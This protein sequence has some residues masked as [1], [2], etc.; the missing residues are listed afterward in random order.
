MKTNPLVMLLAPKAT[1]GVGTAS[2]KIAAALDTNGFEVLPCADILELYQLA[3]EK[4]KPDGPALVLLAGSHAENCV[5]ATYLRTLHPYVGIIVILQGTAEE[6]LLQ[7][8]QAGADTYCFRG[9]SAALLSALILRLQW[10][11]NQRWSQ[12]V[13]HDEPKAGV[14]SLQEQAWSLVTPTGTRVP[15][16]T[17][18]RAFLS[19]LLSAPNQRAT[20]G[21]LIEAVNASYALK[22]PSAQPGRLGVLVSRMRRKLTVHGAVLPLKSMHNWGYMFTGPL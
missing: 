18:E 6:P 4:L 5:A 21:Q 19:F 10:R 8:L 16:T 17:G 9:S 13:V 12:P 7:A 22:D 11:L 20:H 3:Q 2:S 15:L 1:A 14:W